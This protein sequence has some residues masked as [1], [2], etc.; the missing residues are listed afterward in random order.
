MKKLNNILRWYK[1]NGNYNDGRYY[2]RGAFNRMVKL[3]FIL[4]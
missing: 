4:F 3:N 1:D 2:Q